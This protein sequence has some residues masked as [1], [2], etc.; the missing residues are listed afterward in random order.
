[1]K[2]S[3]DTLGHSAGDKLLVDVAL[4]AAAQVRASDLVALYGGDEFIVLRPHASAQQA[5]VVA[6]RIRASAATMPVDG[7]RDDQEPFIV[8]LSIG[9]TEMQREPADDNLERIVQ[10]VDDALYAAIRSGRN[11]VMISG[12]DEL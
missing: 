1:M 4:T 7:L 3:N 12:Q 10:R 8:T 9:I 2:R 5:L 11:R 6:E